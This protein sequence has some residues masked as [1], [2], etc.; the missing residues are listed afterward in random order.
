MMK[1]L[2]PILF[3]SAAALVS[4]IRAAPVISEFMASNARILLDEDG[5]FSDWIEIHNPSGS[6]VSLDGYYLSDDPALLTKWRFP[7][8]SLAAN[9]N[10]LVF[11][12]GKN[13]TN[14]AG[15]LHTNFELDADGEFLALVGPETN[16]IS[17]F[18]PAY[19]EQKEDVS[20]GISKRLV[21]SSLLA[22]YAPQVLVP[23]N[24]AALPADWQ[25]LHFVP[26][27]D[28]FTGASPPALGFDTNQAPQSL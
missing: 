18:V 1:T 28:W 10:L 5:D 13:R 12:S 15:R 20:F 8:V 23:T 25:G 14:T 2:A 22:D 17:G 6:A 19:P 16:I 3:V 21:T 4:S 9:G 26:G 11:A 7:D 24:A 27:D